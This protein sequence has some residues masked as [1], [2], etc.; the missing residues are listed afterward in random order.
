MSPSLVR[1]AISDDAV[2]AVAVLR[3]SITELCVAD[4]QN[5]PETLRQW[6]QNK[7]I[8]AFLSWLESSETY[9]VVGET[10]G[11]VC[12][13]G[14]VHTSGEINL[15]YVQPGRERIGVGGAILSALETRARNWGLSNLRLKSSINARP[16]YERHGYV[17]TGAST[18]GLGRLRCHPYAKLL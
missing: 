4:H 7:T 12:G 11:I 14:S 18:C 17:S 3:Q 6:L 8:E 10:D 2:T 9:V 15:C 16:F 5:D 1:P 13:V